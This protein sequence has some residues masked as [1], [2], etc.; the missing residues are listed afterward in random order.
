MVDEVKD[1]VIKALKEVEDPEV[2]IDV[3]NLGLIYD[4]SVDDAGVVRIRMTFT[5]P[6]CPVGK[7]LLYEV[8]KKVLLIEGVKDLHVDVVF[9]PRWTPLN[10]T[11]EGRER[12]RSRHGYDIVEKYLELSK[13]G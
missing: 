7:H 13:K 8:Y 11:P 4:V 1:R 9:T 10:I 2:E 3:W 12:F 6:G 5:A